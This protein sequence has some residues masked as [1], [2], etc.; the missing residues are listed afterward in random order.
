M[1]VFSSILA[2]MPKNV[3]KDALRFIFHPSAFILSLFLSTTAFAVV[4]DTPTP[5]P[6]PTVTQTAVCGSTFGCVTC[7]AN[8]GYNPSY[9][10]F[11]SS[12]FVL[13]SQGTVNGLSVWL[14]GTTGARVQMAVYADNS[15]TPGN[16]L[17]TSSEATTIEGWNSL[18]VYPSFLS[19]GLYWVSLMAE[20]HCYYYASASELSAR[21]METSITYGPMPTQ[22]PS[23]IVGTGTSYKMYA[24]YCPG[25]PIFSTPTPTLTVTPT[26]I[27]YKATSNGTL[28][29]GPVPA[30]QGTPVC[31]YFDQAPRSSSWEVFNVRG[32]RVSALSF[33]LGEQACLD[34]TSIAPG[35][36][37]VRA[38]VE[39][40]GGG[41]GTLSQK[42]VVLP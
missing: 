28:A 42:V 8:I 39:Y 13:A 30:K 22:A 33:G 25:P 37:I 29:L 21:A 32:Q 24:S 6:S 23:G 16:L 14:T 5:S 11:V 10:V 12:Q 36:Y 7:S 31:L 35:I 15:N 20:Q 2:R 18:S 19:A 41:T 4:T 17:F 38:K 1:I 34:T 9:T 40:A 26:P 3:G 27:L